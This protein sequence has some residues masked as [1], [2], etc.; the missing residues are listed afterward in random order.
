VA[1]VGRPSQRPRS[2]ANDVVAQLRAAGCMAIEIDGR[3][4]RCSTLDVRG[5]PQG[6]RILD[7]GGDTDTIAARTG[8]LAGARLGCAAIPGEWVRRTENTSRL[9]EIADRFARRHTATTRPR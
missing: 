4:R 9:Q 7:L 8:A 2:L 1:V 6:L 5:V 3:A